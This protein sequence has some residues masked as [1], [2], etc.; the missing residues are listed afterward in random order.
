[1]RTAG[2]RAQSLGAAL[3]ACL[4]CACAG[5]AAVP[6]TAAVATDLR[7]A[8][9]VP[10]EA[11]RAARDLAVASLGRHA[12]AADAA[13]S[14]IV[15][16][17]DQQE[18]DGEP[19]TGL[20]PVG[21]DLA[22]A[23]QQPGRAYLSASESLLERG[24]V[25]P[26]LRERISRH[27]AA[28]PLARADAS[29][30]DAWVTEFARL[31]N[32]IS[33]PLGTS[34]VFTVMLPVRLGMSLANYAIDLYRED[35]LPLQ[36]RQAL[37]QWKDFLAR[38]PDAPESQEVA[39]EAARA[40]ARW[41]RMQ[42]SRALD[43]A[44]RAESDGR[45]Q[46][47]VALA[48]RALRIAPGDREALRVRDRAAAQVKEQREA[49]ARSTG[50]A[51]PAGVD[52]AP[53]GTRP[54]V[55]ALLD[56]QGDIASAAIAV[57]RESPIHDEARYALA[58]AYARAGQEAEADAVLE[59]V[60]A[61]G[62]TMARH[63]E[64]TLADPVQSPWRHFVEARSRDRLATAR[65]V[66]FGRLKLPEWTPDG[67]AKWILGATAIPSTVATFPF[68]VIQLPWTPPPPSAR[69]TALQANRYLALHPNGVHAEE[70]RAWLED[71]ES[72]RGNHVAALRVAETREPQR[73]D[74]EP[75]REEAAQQTLEVARKEERVD[76]RA[77]LLDG[78]VQRFPE[79][80]AGGEAREMLRKEIADTT[81]QR[82]ALSRRFLVENPDVAGVRGLGLDPALLDGSN[83][84]GELHPDGVALVGGRRIEVSFVAASGDDSDPPEKRT[85]EVSEEQLARVVARLE[86]TSF[87]NSLIDSDDPVVPN[88]ERDVAFE[89]ARLGLADR[90]DPRPEA[91]ADY[92]YKGMRERYGLVRAR[93]PWLPFDLVVQGSLADLSL[94]AFPRW[95]E[96]KPPP[97]ANL[98]Q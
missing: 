37:A 70:A 38:Y 8:P 98:Y 92:Q 90:V 21:R 81:P 25:E 65:F 30:R 35:P 10:D 33:Q 84:N 95:R 2:R 86:E 29:V 7:F 26:A 63:A 44:Q 94:G 67:V 19:R 42:S 88:A 12:D 83:A 72:A 97:D 13:L 11:D 5:P 3:G 17:D 62:G 55:L 91:R 39:L 24:D 51:L 96:P 87:R 49:A 54:L 76:L 59:Q 14:R 45:P 20:E 85:A 43:A 89:R 40:E 16:F 50:F 80:K 58:I 52:L 28:D 31:F 78:V 32:A 75:L 69:G 15:S 60:A 6:Q 73:R 23:A 79:T 1:M 66:F 34:F 48:E 82:I 57:P 36:R 64:A 74:L 4:A 53:E 41:Q 46:E 71:Y 56:P 68:R 77:A 61:G 22:N 93:E 18:D 47:A 27:V 9:L